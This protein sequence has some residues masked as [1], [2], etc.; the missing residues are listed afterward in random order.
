MV[1]S[2]ADTLDAPTEVRALR[3]FVEGA[4]G[5]DADQERLGLNRGLKQCG[6]RPRPLWSA[7]GR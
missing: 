6:L 5:L 3:G 7:R 4:A 2:V 1:A